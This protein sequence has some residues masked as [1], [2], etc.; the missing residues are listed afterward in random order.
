MENDSFS[1]I[2][3]AVDGSVPS[4]IGQELA[5]FIAKRAGSRV[6]VIHVASHGLIGAAPPKVFESDRHEHPPMGF[7]GGQTPYYE[8]AGEPPVGSLSSEVMSEIVNWFHEKGQKVLDEAVGIFAEQGITVEQKLVDHVDP[9]DG[10]LAEAQRGGYDLIVL[11]AG[12]EEGTEAHLG[13]VARKVAMHATASVLVA[14]EKNRLIRILVPV[15]GSNASEK[16]LNKAVALAR[17]TDAS[18]TLVH[19]LEHPLFTLRPDMSKKIGNEILSKAQLKMA[20]SKAKTKLVDGEP[21]LEIIKIATDG[22]FDVIV[23]GDKGHNRVE[24]F[25]LGAVS[26]YVVHFAK[27]SVLIVR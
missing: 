19:V 1:K 11:G 6:T 21:G 22:N 20:D 14:R 24:R 25:L 16:A 17:K 15:D 23:L 26:D 18:V 4:L 7:T 8:E 10:I 5:A 27:T 3:V 13:I 2:L 9:A 12:G